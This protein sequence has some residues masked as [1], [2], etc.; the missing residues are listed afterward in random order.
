MGAP[1][2]R[3]QAVPWLVALFAILGAAAWALPAQGGTAQRA[4][5]MHGIVTG[6]RRVKAS[7]VA[8]GASKS[9]W[10]AVRCEAG[11]NTVKISETSVF[12]VETATRFYDLSKVC[13]MRGDFRW[14][15]VYSFGADIAKIDTWGRYEQL[16]L[17]EHVEFLLK[18]DTVLL[19]ISRCERVGLLTP[20]QAHRA[21]LDITS[22]PPGGR[23]Y[24]SRCTYTVPLVRVRVKWSTTER[25]R[26]FPDSTET[27]N[28]TWDFRLVATGRKSTAS[29]RP[30]GVGYPEKL[31]PW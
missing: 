20:Q 23:F 6:V 9:I 22:F 1:A 2:L 14:P 4:A 11:N 31:P 24:H 28:Q 10:G 18:P 15:R 19:P 5:P 29:T 3:G 26:D 7:A 16:R 8:L 25:R 13:G 21:L 30:I 17:G 27:K 12:R